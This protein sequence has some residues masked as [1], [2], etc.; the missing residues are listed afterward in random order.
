MATQAER[1]AVI[2]IL[3]ESNFYCGTIFRMPLRERLKL[4]QR[5]EQQ[6]FQGRN[7]QQANPQLQQFPD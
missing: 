2:R 7:G 3:L 4:V 6:M 5:L 1:R